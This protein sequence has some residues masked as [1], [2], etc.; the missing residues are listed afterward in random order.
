VLELGWLELDLL[1]LELEPLPELADV[2]F[3]LCVA[4]DWA[5]TALGSP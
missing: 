1:E 4:D 5:A 2:L 3:W